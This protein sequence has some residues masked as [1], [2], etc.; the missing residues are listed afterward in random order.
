M[1]TNADP[2]LIHEEFIAYLPSLARDLGSPLRAIILQFLHFR[3]RV[4]QDGKVVMTQA[5]I[6][7]RVGIPER[8]L[9][10]HLKWLLDHGHLRKSRVSRSDATSVW[11][12]TLDGNKSEQL[13]EHETIRQ[14]SP[15]RDDA[16]SEEEPSH[17]QTGQKH[18]ADS[19][20]SDAADSAGSS[21]KNPEEDAAVTYSGTEQ[22]QDADSMPLPEPDDTLQQTTRTHG[23]GD[24]GLCDGCDRVLTVGAT[25]DGEAQLCAG[26]M[27]TF[28]LSES[29]DE[30]QPGEMEQAV[31]VV[32]SML[33]GTVVADSGESSPGV[34]ESAQQQETAP[35]VGQRQPRPF[36]T[37]AQRLLVTRFAPQNGAAWEQ[38][39]AT[40]EM[41][42][43]GNGEFYY[44]PEAH[45]AIY[46]SRCQ[47]ESRTPRPDLWLRFFIEDRAKHIA[48]LREEAL[49][50]ERVDETP[51]DREA[52][53]NEQMPPAEWGPE[54][55]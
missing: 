53:Y 21:Y 14:I 4:S 54:E 33:G 34:M 11:E 2:R 5:E 42:S 8:T 23:E 7:Q 20:G 52:R 6:G 3:A 40:A 26:C 37:V 39:W 55:G 27:A 46:L 18:V 30:Q 19:A 44:D 47:H 28:L 15:D 10:D 29:A 12:V 22:Q 25:P 36:P 35:H 50:R 38:S 48:V 51:E 13:Y 1:T 45:L 17:G 16:P 41:Q 9:R 49:K 43:Q 24:V 31:A 32:E